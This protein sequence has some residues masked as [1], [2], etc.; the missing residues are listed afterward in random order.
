MPAGS[1]ARLSGIRARRLRALPVALA[2]YWATA[3]AAA[4][5]RPPA[6][7]LLAP[8]AL[9]CDGQ[10]T[11]LAVADPQPQFSWSLTASSP[12]LHG[13][14]Q[15][16]WQIEVADAPRRFASA[17]DLLWNSGIV[18]SSAT[19]EI[20]YKGSA[21]APQHEYGWRVRVW[22]EHGHASPWS[23]VARWTQAPIWHAHWIESPDAAA[24]DAP[25]PLFRKSFHL[26]RTVARA[27]LYAS[28]L[29]QDELR[30]DGRKVGDDLLTPGWSDYRKTIFY[31]SYDVTGLLRPGENVLGVMRLHHAR[32]P[33]M[34]SSVK[35]RGSNL[36]SNRRGFS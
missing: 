27:V 22:D 9:R 20:Q 34:G 26:Q 18:R 2:A 10:S 6:P 23:A 14:G 33:L 7:D 35:S 24:P 1:T 25:L 29:G 19:S 5:P 32:S 31:D 15:T 13:V 36:R 28:G 3:W 30:I 11:P 21:L 17:Q 12:A 4:Q 8:S 16:A